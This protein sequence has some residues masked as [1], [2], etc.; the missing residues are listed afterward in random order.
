M[1]IYRMEIY[2]SLVFLVSLF[3]STLN[4]QLVEGRIIGK[5]HIDKVGIT[6]N[7][8]DD[9]GITPSQMINVEKDG[10]FKWSGNISRSTVDATLRIGRN[11]F[12]IRLEKKQL[13]KINITE[14]ERDKWL[15]E[16]EGKNASFSY[17]YSSYLQE[18]N[19]YKLA[20]LNNSLGKAKLKE[21]SVFLMDL[22]RAY[23]RVVIK[24][25]NL[26]PQEEYTYY[27]QLTK[28][29]RD[30]ILLSYYNKKA[31][32][33]QIKLSQCSNFMKVARQINP[34]SQ[35]TIRSGLIYF[36][37][38]GRI[39]P[40]VLDKGWK[41]PTAYGMESLRVIKQY[42]KNPVALK[43][44]VDNNALIFFANF[45][46]RDDVQLY[47]KELMNLTNNDPVLKQKYQYIAESTFRL[48]PGK[49]ALDNT[50]SDLEGKQYKLSDF[51]GKVLYIDVWATWCIPCR[52]EIP[53][54]KELVERY[55][56]NNKITFLSISRDANVQQW[57]SM[58]NKIKPDWPQ[59]NLNTQED[60]SFT[61]GWGITS[62]PRFILI[63][64]EGNIVNAN[65]L[66][67]SDPKIISILNA[68]INK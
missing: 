25:N 53:Y 16:F 26:T 60:E 39:Q 24:L 47:W 52:K 67:P 29:T 36:F 10:T 68:E 22:E 32:Q 57:K 34:N 61:E 1:K 66:R 65:A 56:G 31:R 51:F 13:L 46:S 35:T 45:S 49:R 9:I 37:I 7:N 20:K 48:L 40:E 8:R 6:L 62:I 23:K 19:Y 17:F 21:E 63:N 44:L 55:Q 27:N 5:Q 64:K 14:N 59:F 54:F 43:L 4:A 28:D 41:D 18:L 50:M 11:V 3:T 33:G 15:A 2:S 58:L 38:S 42:V 30:N 12:G